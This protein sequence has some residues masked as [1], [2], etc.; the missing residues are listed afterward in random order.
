IFWFFCIKTKE[1]TPSH[2]HSKQSKETLRFS[3]A[4]PTNLS[5]VTLSKPAL[6][7]PALSLTKCRNIKVS[8]C[9]PKKTTP[10]TVTRKVFPII[11]PFFT[12]KQA[13]K[14]LGQEPQ[15]IRN[16]T[17]CKAAKK[18]VGLKRKGM[19]INYIMCCYPVNYT[20]L[21]IQTYFAK[22]SA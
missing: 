8:K 5:I 19:G 12:K 17:Y 22:S 4:N 9:L 15:H 3:V 14:Q 10:F 11:I 6:S 7:K 16:I 2:C 1:Q 20:M 21:D 18:L 13:Y